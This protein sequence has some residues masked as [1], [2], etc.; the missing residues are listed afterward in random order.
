MTLVAGTI[1]VLTRL[2]RRLAHHDRIQLLHLF[3]AHAVWQA[4]VGKGAV[5]T[6]NFQFMQ[7]QGCFFIIHCAVWLTTAAAPTT[8]ALPDFILSERF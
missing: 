4:Q 2:Q 3:L 5:L 8:A 6:G 7:V 1:Q